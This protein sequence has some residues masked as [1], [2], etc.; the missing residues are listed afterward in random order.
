MGRKLLFGILLIF[1]SVTQAKNLDGRTGFGLTHLAF[2][3]APALSAKFFHTS[4]IV[5]G[6]VVGFDTS[7][8]KY[9]LGVRSMRHVIS[10]ENMNLFVGIAGYLLSDPTPLPA[11]GV[12]F[13]ALL[14]GE[15]FLAGLPNLGF[16]FEVGLGLRFLRNATFR[17]IGGAFASGA[18]HYY[19]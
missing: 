5:T 8:N 14:G 7:L 19:F 2:T 13:D 18:V 15:F 16:Q 6:F 1:S 12:Q 17:S 11:T 4:L 9:Q 3:G 10:E